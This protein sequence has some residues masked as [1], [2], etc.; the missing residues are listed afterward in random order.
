[1]DYAI[2]GADVGYRWFQARGIKPL[3]P[4]GYGLSYT[5]FDHGSLS[6]SSRDGQ[7]IATVDIRNTGTR[8][9]ADVAQVYVRVPGAKANRLAG[10]A[11]VFLQPGEHRQLTIPLERRLLADFDPASHGWQMRGGEYRVTEGRSSEDLGTPVSLQLPAG[12]L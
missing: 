10:Y 6:V 12:H 5:R 4:F 2:E 8:A 1:V 7:V 3:F 9:G 11:K